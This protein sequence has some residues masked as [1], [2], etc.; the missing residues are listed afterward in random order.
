MSE[1]S[2]EVTGEGLTKEP[3]GHPE[4]AERNS[5][6]EYVRKLIELFGAAGLERL[7]PEEQ[8]W[9]REPG[10]PKPD[11]AVNDPSYNLREIARVTKER[12]LTLSSK[13]NGI[14]L[15]P[16]EIYYMAAVFADKDDRF[17][18]DNYPLAPPETQVKEFIDFVLNHQGPVNIAE[19][20][21]KLIEITDGSV[22]DA[23][24]VG[25][26]ASRLAARNLDKRLY[27]GIKVTREM[28]E[29]WLSKVAI[30]GDRNKPKDPLGDNY[31]FWTAMFTRIG[32][33]GSNTNPFFQMLD[34]HSARVMTLS[35]QFFA[36]Q[37]T[38]T[39]HREA[40]RQGKEIAELLLTLVREDQ[41][42][43]EGAIER[44]DFE[45]LKKLPPEARVG[46]IIGSLANLPP[47]GKLLFGDN[48]ELSR[49]I[50]KFDPLEYFSA[51]PGVSALYNPKGWREILSQVR[52]E[53][54]SIYIRFTTE[55]MVIEK[56]PT[57]EILSPEAKQDSSWVES[58]LAKIKNEKGRE[59][60][61][62]WIAMGCSNIDSWDIFWKGRKIPK[63]ATD[64]RTMIYDPQI[65]GQYFTPKEWEEI[66]VN[67][68]SACV[69]KGRE[70]KTLVEGQEMTVF[71]RAHEEVVRSALILPEDG[72]RPRISPELLAA[73]DRFDPKKAAQED[74]VKALAVAM[75][76]RSWYEN[77]KTELEERLS[78]GLWQVAVMLLRQNAMVILGDEGESRRNRIRESLSG[79][80]EKA[81]KGNEE[82]KSQARKMLEIVYQLGMQYQS[83]P[84]Y[85]LFA[86]M[87][88]PSVYGT[89][90]YYLERR[91]FRGNPGNLPINY[92]KTI[93]R[94]MEKRPQ[95]LTQ[96]QRSLLR[97]LS[98][99]SC[100]GYASGLEA[101]A[102]VQERNQNDSNP[103]IPEVPPD[104]S[105]F[106]QSVMDW[107]AREGRSGAG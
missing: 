41:N 21:G 96:H 55:G 6:R 31:Y 14:P 46:I 52:M 80:V 18:P 22:L 10:I 11:A 57:G 78:P 68:L 53:V 33:A 13:N 63:T 106:A 26:M 49:E 50:Y 81:E 107:I 91:M 85:S 37:P 58:E 61:K 35:R 15:H 64:L 34:R 104:E 28:Q 74:K 84:V 23:A 76:N 66:V 105:S 79:L 73:V 62:I 59:L 44:L 9:I 43:T 39:D 88:D 3:A 60:V 1:F 87:Y 71:G 83:H 8:S 95:D 5:G 65:R 25:M 24:A 16:Y 56:R 54:P 98:C 82:E 36:R 70:F 75:G 45:T 89:A 99:P 12:P 94:L 38:K 69:D 47:G 97:R 40:F 30:F 4:S 72:L 42:K 101:Q 77:H 27:P 86:T 67:V 7:T 102:L 103:S 92:A 100:Y 17:N 29:A 93:I 2:A 90:R 32:I 48:G 51:L 19:Q 20:F